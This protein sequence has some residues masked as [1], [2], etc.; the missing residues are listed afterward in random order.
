VK[1][2]DAYPWISEAF[3]VIR[4]ERGG[5]YVVCDCPIT[6]HRTATLRL[7]LGRDGRLMFGCHACGPKA[8]LEILRAARLSW[9]DTFPEGARI[10]RQHQE[11]VERYPYCDEAGA[12]LYQTVR[13]E[14]GRNGRDK[15]FVQRRPNPAFNPK[16][17]FGPDNRKWIPNL[18]GVR[19]V[20][21]RLPELC[22][23]DRSAVVYVVAGEKDADS[24]RGIG[25][26]STTNVCGERSEWLRDYS[27]ALAGR[28]VAVIADADDPG[29]RHAEKVCGALLDYA[30][31]L[32]KLEL[33]GAKDATAFLLDR[34]KE[35]VTR[36]GDLRAAFVA[37]VTDS[38]LWTG[39]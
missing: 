19:R 32:R 7:W 38:K 21:Y 28:H 1:V 17:L 30:T 16:R 9:K 37:A 34:R 12:L 29:R 3:S 22:R 33:P 20:L 8:K 25:L 4:E 18:D 13:L 5:E 6:N 2:L 10:E 24:L 14:P 27:A 26:V 35:G 11:V 23:A 15:D 31:S 36:P 39:V